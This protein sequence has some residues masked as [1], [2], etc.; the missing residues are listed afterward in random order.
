L[1]GQM[2]ATQPPGL[3]TR[4]I[5]DK[6]ASPPCPEEGVK[7]EQA[8]TRSAKPSGRGSSSKNPWITRARLP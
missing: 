1:F 7:A 8:T 5:S 6:P 2:M 3:H 4:S